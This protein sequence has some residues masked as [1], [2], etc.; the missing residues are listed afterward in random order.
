MNST[1]IESSSGWGQE[2]ITL[3]GIIVSVVIQLLLC[4]E[5]AFSRVQKSSCQRGA[6]GEI[7]LQV[8]SKEKA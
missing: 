2:N 8:E 7:S 6:N 4:A 5:R 3:V 1:S